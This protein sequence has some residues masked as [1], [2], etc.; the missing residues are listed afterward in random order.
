MSFL[1]CKVAVIFSNYTGFYNNFS[2][3]KCYL[4]QELNLEYYSSHGN[5]LSN[6]AKYHV[7]VR[8]SFLSF[9][10]AFCILIWQTNQERVSNMNLLHGLYS[11]VIDT[12]ARKASDSRFKSRSNQKYSPEILISCLSLNK[13]V[14]KIS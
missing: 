9:V 1:G 4:G 6:Q 5:L 3:E 10:V 11:L 14:N 12:L 2:R 7:L 8:I 13:S